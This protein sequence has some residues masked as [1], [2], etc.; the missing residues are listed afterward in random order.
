MFAKKIKG[1]N[2]IRWWSLLILVLFIYFSLRSEIIQLN[3]KLSK[4]LQPM[5]IYRYIVHILKYLIFFC[6]RFTLKYIFWSTGVPAL[7]V[8]RVPRR[9]DI[10]RPKTSSLKVHRILKK[11]LKNMM[12][13]QLTIY[14]CIELNYIRYLQVVKSEWLV[15]NLIELFIICV[16]YG[17]IVNLYRSYFFWMNRVSLRTQRI[18]IRLVAITIEFESTLAFTPLHFFENTPF[19]VTLSV[20][21]SDLSFHYLLRY[22]YLK[23]WLIT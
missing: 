11:K 3:L 7:D 17:N 18:E 12:K 8:T 9:R 21:L 15:L 2:R 16:K 14:E 13:Y 4:I 6:T 20:H 1:S 10:W 23:L 5:L 19:R 22:P